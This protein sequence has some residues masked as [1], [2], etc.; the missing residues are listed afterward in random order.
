MRGEDVVRIC[1]CGGGEHFRK[2]LGVPKTAAGHFDLA[3]VWGRMPRTLSCE[4]LLLWEGA[5]PLGELRAGRVIS[6]GFSPRSSLTLAS[7]ST[8]RAVLS[9][10]RSILRGDG[11]CILPQ[12]LPLPKEWAELTAAEQVMLAGVALLM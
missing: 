10:Q 11:R 12:D 4:T 2:I 9:V 6:C 7:L 8:E 5:V 3:V 1:V